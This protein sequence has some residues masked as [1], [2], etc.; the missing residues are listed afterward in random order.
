[1]VRGNL[2]P[3]LRYSSERRGPPSPPCYFDS[4]THNVG[5]TPCVLRTQG[6]WSILV[7][8]PWNSP[9]PPVLQS[10]SILRLNLTEVLTE[11]FSPRQCSHILS[12]CLR[13]LRTRDGAS[14]LSYTTHWTQYFSCDLNPLEQEVT[15]RDRGTCAL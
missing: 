3:R 12:L 5:F 9:R 10:P 7:R 1:M 8:V 11:K 6:T 13:L 4:P 15:T 14:S 2:S